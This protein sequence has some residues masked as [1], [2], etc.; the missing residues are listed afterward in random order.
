[1]VKKFGIVYKVINLITK[2]CYIGQTTQPL[3]KRKINHFYSNNKN[4][5][6]FYNALKKYGKNTFVWDVLC[7]C[8]T[9][10]ELNE[11]EMYYIKELN[12]LRP[13]GYNL[14]LGGGGI[15]G[16]KHTEETKRKIGEKSKGNVHN[17][18]KTHTKEHRE[19]LRISNTGKKRS[20]ESKMN[21]SKGKK[22]VKFTEDHKRK[23]SESHMG[24]F[25]SEE[26]KK[27]LSDIGMGHI[28]SEETREKL[29]KI[30]TG[31]YVSEETKKKMKESHIGKKYKKNLQV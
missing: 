15:S 8:S 19:K 9:R 1:M 14:T 5:Y 21:I 22:G 12:T 23:L 18:G 28:V 29:R 11:K 30:N 6:Y 25:V 20:I 7:E 31:K 3:E 24:Q 2:K 13:N 4:T 17:L 26:T 10:E 27:K 16:Y